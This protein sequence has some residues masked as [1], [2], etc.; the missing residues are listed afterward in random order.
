MSHAERPVLRRGEFDHVDSIDDRPPCRRLDGGEKIKAIPILRSEEAEK[1]CVELIGR[2]P[3]RLRLNPLVGSTNFI[4]VRPAF[5]FSPHDLCAMHSSYAH[6]PCGH[7]AHCWREE[8]GEEGR[9]VL[10]DTT[11][12]TALAA[13]NE[14][15]RSGAPL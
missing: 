9:A 4:L 8:D 1:M 2:R 13:P 7:C 3:R 14:R 5:D 10:L 15:N 12:I 11:A 6:L